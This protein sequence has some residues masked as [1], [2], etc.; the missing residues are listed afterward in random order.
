MEKTNGSFEQQEKR[1]ST[2]KQ[3]VHAPPYRRLARGQ[4]ST[5]CEELCQPH[6]TESQQ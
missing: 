2:L 4:E 3:C 5:K 1:W 6:R